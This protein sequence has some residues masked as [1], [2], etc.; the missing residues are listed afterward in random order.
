MAE[1]PKL[2]KL[3]FTVILL[4]LLNAMIGLDA[5][6]LPVLSTAIAGPASLISWLLIGLLGL[7]I[8]MYYAE[9]ISLYP[10]SGG[11]YEIAK[12]TYG[13]FGSFM[14]GWLVWLMGNIGMALCIVWATSFLM[15]SEH[16][17]LQRF[18][19]ALF[20]I[21]IFNLIAFIG[22]NFSSV[23]L[24]GFGIFAICVIS[25]TIAPA[26]IDIP[27]LIGGSIQTQFSISRMEPF[28]IHHGL[29]N[30]MLFL[31]GTMFVIAD[32]L[33]G[34]EVVSF[35][36][37]EV[38]DPA[39][40]LPRALIIAFC[41]IMVL[42]ILF[43]VSSYGILTRSEYMTSATPAIT[44]VM[45][46]LGPGVETALTWAAFIIIIGAAATW[47]VAGSRLLM[48]M[49][50]DGLFH[51][52]MKDI[53]AHTQTPHKSIIFQTIATML[54]T[55]L[56]FRGY[57]EG[58]RDPY[59]IMHH[60]LIFIFLII[61]IMIL[62]ALVISRKK[63][64]EQ[65]RPFRAP[66]GNRGPIVVCFILIIIAIAWVWSEPALG[67]DHI[68][69]A[70]SFIL[71]GIPLYLLVELY[72]DPK[73]ITEVK[74]FTAY[75]TLFTER[76]A[77]PIKVRAEIMELLGDLRGKTILEYGC[78]VGTL[79]LMLAREVGPSGR[80]FAVDI[81][82]NDLKITQKRIERD[83]WKTHERIHGRVHIIHDEEQ[84]TRVHPSIPYANII[85]SFGMLGYIQNVH[86]VLKGMNDILPVGGKVCF[87]EYAD[88]FRL[89]PNVE[90]LAR[91]DIVERIFRECGFSVRV[92]RKKGLLWN[93][94]Y[95]YGIKSERDVAFI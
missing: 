48:A 25:F 55:A 73:M 7:F 49:A 88:F 13:R 64:P 81:S 24:A 41:T 82:R 12:N 72:Y 20:W 75:F 4:V 78:S 93:Y 32:V 5:Y 89:I 8:I 56:V 23:V 80:I 94:I 71:L 77:V 76:I 43:V 10:F 85:V 38:K 18:L 68:K 67:W 35:L 6:Y 65:V 21:I 28:F 34:F 50:K 53:H 52:S 92:I 70:T 45:K 46:T 14:M 15:P 19:F 83:I 39:R 11:L 37:G 58:W 91:N 59:G 16:Q 44:L 79:T 62:Y 40:N 22:I 1:E 17:L 42:N 61:T 86:A 60:V 63:N 2:K 26:I 36:A 3:S 51:K 9:L 29:Q 54:F 27:A 30:N 57:W 33:V 74:D 84:V 66:F 31:I 90:W 95:V 87:V 69:K 47:P